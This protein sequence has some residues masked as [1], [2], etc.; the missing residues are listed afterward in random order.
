MD[1]PTTVAQTMDAPTTIAPLPDVPT[2]HA[3][4]TF[5]PLSVAP[6]PVLASRLHLQLVAPKERQMG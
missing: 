2:T 1:A 6:A 3:P 5:A 4:T